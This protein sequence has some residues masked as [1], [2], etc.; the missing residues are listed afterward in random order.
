MK[1]ANRL[2][3]WS[4]LMWWGLVLLLAFVETRHALADPA[5]GKKLF[6]AS[7]CVSCHQTSGPV[8]TLPVTERSKINGPPLWFVGSKFRQVWLIAWLKTPTPIRRVQYGSLTKGSNKHPALSAVDAEEVGSYLMTLTDSALKPGAVKNK[9]LNRRTRFRAEKLF[10]KKQVC[11]GC[12]QYPSK[13]GN[14]GG[15]AGPSLVGAGKRLRVDWIYAFMNDPSRYY[16]NGRMPVYGDQAFNRFTEKELKL[17]A[18][19]IGNW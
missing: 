12:H 10:V 19:Y 18:R 11:F 1:V 3:K 13:K 17:L 7:Q 6:E 9:K 15:F 14:I 8:E 16:P 2:G 5:K 4:P